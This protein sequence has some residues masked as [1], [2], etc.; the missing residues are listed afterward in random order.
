ML[1]R[2]S[3]QLCLHRTDGSSRFCLPKM[4]MWVELCVIQPAFMCLSPACYQE[5][6]SE[7][8]EAQAVCKPVTG[9]DPTVTGSR[10][11]GSRRADAKVRDLLVHILL[12]LADGRLISPFPSYRMW[13]LCWCDRPVIVY[14]L[15]FLTTCWACSQG[16]E[17]KSY[18]LSY[19]FRHLPGLLLFCLPVVDCRLP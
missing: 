17:F 9:T 5:P 4:F 16:K 19:E 18:A 15:L 2:P 8:A 7:N 6:G 10:C 14:S 1:R 11:L 12:V 3:V 13:L